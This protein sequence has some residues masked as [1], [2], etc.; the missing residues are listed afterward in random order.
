MYMIKAEDSFSEKE[1]VYISS[2]FTISGAI[3][4]DYKN[5]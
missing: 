2:K 5:Q 1:I 4:K 3:I